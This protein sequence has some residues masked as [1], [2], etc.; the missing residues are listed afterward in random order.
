[1]SALRD[2]RIRAM[3]I[4]VAVFVLLVAVALYVVLGNKPTRVLHADFATAIGV[5]PGS[6]VRVLGV[7]VGSIQSVKPHGTQVAVT[8]RVNKDV[9]VP[10]DAR[11]I[12]IAPNLVSD[13]YVQLAPAYGGGPR[14]ADNSTIDVS[15]TATPL[16]LDSLYDSVRKFSSDLGPNGVNARGAL[17]SV[18]HTGA[19]NLDG[20]GRMF[21]TTIANLGQLSQTL[22]HSSGDLYA[23]ISNLNR[24]T[25][26]LRGNDSQIRLAEQQ[27]ADVSGFLADDRQD[28]AGALRG[29]AQALAEVKGFI[30]DNRDALKRNVDKLANITQVLMDQR[31]SLAEVLDN[32]PVLT[33][34]A[35]NAY[36]PDTRTLM[37][38]GNLLEIT[39]AFGNLSQKGLE[40]TGADTRPVCAAASAQTPALK[41]QCS[42]LQTNGLTAVGPS[43]SGT[44][45]ALPFPPAGQVYAGGGR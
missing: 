18:I 41:L 5:Y 20:N 34:N 26:M 1:M 39:K 17:S 10:S 8:M 19:A 35:L 7:K 30:T 6:D 33:Q 3:E 25:A 22:N 42:R 36:D 2:H 11:A 16:E 43:G 40:G 45:P 4:I 12:V 27:L 37:S 29:L 32:A 23:T 38:R 28:L 24:F 31:A 9:P 21:N 14:M 15:R 13:R 44:L